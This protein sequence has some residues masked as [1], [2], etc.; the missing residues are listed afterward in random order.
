MEILPE[1]V[2]FKRCEQRI[3]NIGYDE[4]YIVGPVI[5]NY[6]SAF[7]T[8]HTMKFLFYHLRSNCLAPVIFIDILYTVNDLM[9]SI[10]I[11][12]KNITCF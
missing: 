6:K 7:N 3:R 2:A 10:F 8:R 5:T 9:I 11:N 12:H 1:I 4:Q